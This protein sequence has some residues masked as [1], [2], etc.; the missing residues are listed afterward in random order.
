[1]TFLS[2]LII[3]WTQC[4]KKPCN[5][6]QSLQW[7]GPRLDRSQAHLASAPAP[8][9]SPSKSGLVFSRPTPSGLC[10]VV[11]DG[12]LFDVNVNYID[13]GHFPSP[14]LALELAQWNGLQDSRSCRDGTVIFP[15]YS[16]FTS[17]PQPTSAPPPD[18]PSQQP[19]PV[20]TTSWIDPCGSPGFLS[21]MPAVFTEGMARKQE[22]QEAQQRADRRTI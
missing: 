5:F 21:Q 4:P 1:V 17:T 18:T 20:F 11:S 16:F 8:P 10:R 15:T 14:A 9:S 12:V 22:L 6:I 7:A 19:T 2:L 3:Y 13:S